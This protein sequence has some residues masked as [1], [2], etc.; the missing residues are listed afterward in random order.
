M[1]FAVLMLSTCAESVLENS[2]SVTT[3]DKEAANQTES[4]HANAYDKVTNPVLEMRVPTQ[5]ISFLNCFLTQFQVFGFSSF[6]NT[7]TPTHPVAQLAAA[8]R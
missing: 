2:L 6:G 5:S 8:T 1:V 4:T 3:A 7:N